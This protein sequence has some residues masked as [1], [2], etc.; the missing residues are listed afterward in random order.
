MACP[1]DTEFGVQVVLGQGARWNVTGESY[2]SSL[3]VA[4]GAEI[5]GV[6]TVDGEKVEP[7]PGSYA[8]K[9]VLGPK[10]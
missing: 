2:L 7:V 9:I 10:V 6:M 4:P 1:K 3:T 5:S 8:G